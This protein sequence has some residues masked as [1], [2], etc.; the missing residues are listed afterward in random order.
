MSNEILLSVANLHVAFRQGSEWV[1]AVNGISFDIRFG[2]TFALVGES[3]SGK[4]VTA[5]S[6]LR[7]LPLGGRILQGSAKL[8]GSD[9]F[10]LPE[11]ELCK[12]RGRR[13]GVIFQD[14]MSSLNPVMTIGQQIGEVLRLHF[15]H[16][17]AA[18]KSRAVEL[19]EQVGMPRPAEH[20]DE[21]PHQFS[22]GMRQRAMIAIALAGEP[23]LLIADEP[24]TALDVT[25]QAQILALLKR[26][27]KE[28]GM[29]LWLI[30][31]DLGIVSTM[32]DRVAVMRKGEIVEA[33]ESGPFFEHPQ[34]PYSLQLFDAR[35]RLESCLGRKQADNSLPPLLEVRDFK[36][37]YPIKKGLL[38]RV[39]DYVRAVDG[40]S[41][42]LSKGQT[43]ALVGESG[44]GKTTLGKAMLNLIDSSGGQVLFD[45]MDVTKASGEARRRRCGE[46][47]I[48]FQDPFSSMN[49]RMVVGD[50]IEEG[51][52][53]LQPESTEHQRR[54]RSE[55]LLAAVGLEKAARMRYPL[56]FSGGQRQR[57]CIARALAVNPR[58]IICDEP[59]SALDVSVQ[60]QI[61]GLLKELRKKQGL[62]Y[63]FISHDLAVVAE[64]ADFV[65]VMRGGKIVEIGRVEQVLFSP[66]QDYTRKLLQAVPGRVSKQ[67]ES[68]TQRRNDAT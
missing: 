9:L 44:C 42:C 29:A 52:K 2:E 41:F 59:T 38:Q 14:P 21:Y 37:Y 6:V 35:P 11:Y 39:V 57:I 50:I 61:I 60:K 24:T 16:K 36:V 8:D 12:I 26:L 48:I 10:K 31:H 49:P 32:A 47:Q 58:L 62:S 23:D 63:L 17:G 64:L 13:V 67:K 30:T 33:T 65:A 56:D 5:L 18:L 25:I 45:G 3:G 22:G 40:V 54:E 43:L 53:A 46:M 20:F 68:L 66:A 34:H 19:L 1:S 28:R 4:S 27:Q 7:L 55:E 51:I 15:G